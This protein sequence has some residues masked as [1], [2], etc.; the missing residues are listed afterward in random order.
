MQGDKTQPSSAG[1]PVSSGQVPQASEKRSQRPRATRR[2]AGGSWGAEH[3]HAHRR[4]SY[5]P[6]RLSGTGLLDGL[7]TCGRHCTS[8]ASRPSYWLRK[9]PRDDLQTL[10]LKHTAV[11]SAKTCTH[12]QKG[13]KT[14]EKPMADSSHR[15]NPRCGGTLTY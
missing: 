14:W 7:T 3:P 11:A 2:W 1:W 12:S 5:A 8:E 9:T 6:V 10:I 15:A 4:L 13:A